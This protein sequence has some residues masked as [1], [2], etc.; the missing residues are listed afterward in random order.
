[1]ATK[2]AGTPISKL[3]RLEMCYMSDNEKEL[4]Q[5]IRD[6]KNPMAVSKYFFNLFADYLQTH[7]PSP[8]NAAVVPQESA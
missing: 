1:M 8:E 6:S 5:I 3:H 4:I 2:A 7:V